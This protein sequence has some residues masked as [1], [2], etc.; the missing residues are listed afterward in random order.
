MLT[1]SARWPATRY[2]CIPEV[3]TDLPTLIGTLELLQLDP[4]HWQPQ[5]SENSLDQNRNNGPYSDTWFLDLPGNYS[6]TTRLDS[7]WH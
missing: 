6:G 2:T 5:C 1:Q 3:A 4:S 7:T